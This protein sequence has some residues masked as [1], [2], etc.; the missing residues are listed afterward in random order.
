MLAT[1]FLIASPKFIT[2]MLSWLLG[3]M[4]VVSLFLLNRRRNKS[5]EL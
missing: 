3:V 1:M 4:V 5:G 2:L